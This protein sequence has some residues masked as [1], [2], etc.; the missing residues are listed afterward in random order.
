MV[1]SFPSIVEG[2]H[3]FKREMEPVL[4]PF[5]RLSQDVTFYLL[6]FLP[7]KDQLQMA[8][9]CKRLHCLCGES[10]W[11]GSALKV[12]GNEPDNCD[13][14]VEEC[15]E[16]YLKIDPSKSWKTLAYCL[17][18]GRRL[19]DLLRTSYGTFETLKVLSPS[20]SDEEDQVRRARLVQSGWGISMNWD[21]HYVGHHHQDFQH[22][23]GSRW[24]N[25]EARWGDWDEGEMISGFK[26]D[27]YKAALCWY[28]GM[29]SSW[30]SLPW[31]NGVEEWLRV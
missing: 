15:F 3:N 17:A 30:S 13:V 26:S 23:K 24:S 22:G 9:T 4:D 11:K 1:T 18:F 27:H 2:L 16:N 12:L 10:H 28:K 6:S 31:K 20:D 19:A 7:L 14:G 29:E 5:S 8:S 21:S 25:R